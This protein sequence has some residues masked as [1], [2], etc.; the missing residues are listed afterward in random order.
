[1]VEN[2]TKGVRQV[3]GAGNLVR[4]RRHCGIYCNTCQRRLAEL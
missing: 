3:L 2:D 4:E 1:M